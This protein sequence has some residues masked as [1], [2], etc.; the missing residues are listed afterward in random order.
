MQIEK[1]ADRLSQP[2][3]DAA[4]VTLR[5][6][7]VATSRWRPVPDFLIIG[8]KRGGTTSLWNY[9]LSHPSVLPMFPA[10]QHLKSSHY[11]YA[12]YA[13]GPRWYRSHFS[14]I[15]RQAWLTRRDKIA[16]VAGEASPYYLF[17]PHVP[18]RVRATAPNVRLI[19]LLRDPVARAYSHYRE[20]LHEG[21]ETLSF[22]DALAAEPDRLD[23]E[24]DHMLD[25]PGY[26]SVAHDNF[27]YR[28][29]GVYLPQ[30]QRWYEHFPPSQFV[31][32]RSE[33]FYRD[34]QSAYN[35]VVSFLGLGHYQLGPI[36]K[37]N[38]HPAAPIDDS[39]RRELRAFYRP[40]NR[41]LYDAIGR[42]YGW[43]N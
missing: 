2:G 26:H 18:E 36:R 23:G 42:D 33:D 34:P 31:L 7:G 19:V 9:L 29:R 40:H 39:T 12:N 41:R 20:R 28:E 22:E 25:D 24:W 37:Y 13:E 30:L 27:A 16:P 4:K 15:A 43:D 3:R 1:V 35:D 10:V 38:Y 6:Y 14:S 32:L 17:G 8:T 11:F 5:R 21:V